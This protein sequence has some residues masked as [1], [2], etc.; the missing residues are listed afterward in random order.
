MF[1]SKKRVVDLSIPDNDK[2]G[3]VD[4]IKM[5]RDL[6]VKAV[7]IT[8]NIKHPYNGDISI[9]LQGPNGESINV[10]GPSRKPGSDIKET[11]S[12]EKFEAF[13][14]IKSKGDWKL[15]VID[16]GARDNGSL[17]DWSL[18][19]K[20]A[21]SK[22]SEIF[23]SDEESLSSTQYC[24]QGEQVQ[25]ISLEAHVEHGFV[26]DLVLDLVSPSGK[27][28]NLQTKVGG[29]NK[30]I[31]T[32]FGQDVLSEMLGE[33]SKGKWSLKI[34]DTMPR[35][36]GRLVS[37]KL[38]LKTGKPT[39][40]T[41]PDNLTKI[42]GIGPKIAG[43]LNDGGITTFAQLADTDPSVIKTMLENAGPRF[44]MHDPGSWPRQAKLAAD[45]NWIELEKLQDE[46]DGGK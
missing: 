11:F 19:L 4:T 20:L 18:N 8:V 39:P 1:Y 28:V 10:H 7:D 14:G 9:E 36:S 41:S 27:M 38:N 45:G 16:S 32:T 37:W 33:K 29:G 26:G 30:E 24:H 21:N 5:H 44:Q 35:D 46:L 22:K 40:K 15:K 42:E 34:N 23:I 12:G 3:L 31:K 6:T 17:V 25:E 13:K 43:I 2:N